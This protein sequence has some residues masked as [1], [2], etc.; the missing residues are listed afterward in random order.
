MHDAAVLR[1]GRDLDT[2]STGRLLEE[3]AVGPYRAIV[4]SIRGQTWITGWAS[5]TVDPTDPFPDSLTVDDIW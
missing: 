5:Y 3:T 1:P 4:P 2:V